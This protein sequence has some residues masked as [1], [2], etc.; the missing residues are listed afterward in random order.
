MPSLREEEEAAVAEDQE[1]VATAAM[2]PG[3]CVGPVEGLQAE[4]LS[5]AAAGHMHE[6]LGVRHNS[7]AFRAIDEENVG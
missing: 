7:S 4:P 6:Y 3:T 1:G 5:A 2:P